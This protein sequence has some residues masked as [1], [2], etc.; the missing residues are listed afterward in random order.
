MDVFLMLLVKMGDSE[1]EYRAPKIPYYLETKKYLQLKYKLNSNELHMEF[2]LDL[3]H[4]LWNPN[5]SFLGVY[6]RSKCLVVVKVSHILWVIDMIFCSSKILF[7]LIFN[8]VDI[9]KSIASEYMKFKRG[10]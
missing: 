2:Y 4:D 9:I 8:F 6:T 1:V 3:L 10:L 5:D 7:L